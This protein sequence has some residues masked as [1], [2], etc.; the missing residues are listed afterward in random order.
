M[1]KEKIKKSRFFRFTRQ[2]WVFLLFAI[3]IGAAAVIKGI[4]LIYLVF[5]MMICFMF[6]SSILAIIS[7]HNLSIAR[8]VPMHIFAGKPFPVEIVI[9]NKK[10][11]Y[12]SFSLVI[13]DILE[14]EDLKNRYLI[15]VPAQTSISTT[16]Q[17]CIQKRGEYTFQGLKISTNY[18]LDFFSRGFIVLNPEKIVVYP[19]IVRLNP[20][21]LADM[22]IE[23][24]K[25]LDREGMGSEVYGFRKYQHGDDSRFI[26]WKLSAKTSQLIVTKFSQDQN[27]N[28]CI[29]FDNTMNEITDESLE[30]FESTVTFTASV[31]SFFV[32]KGFKVKLVTHSGEIPFGE[33]NK[34]LLKMLTHLALIQPISADKATKDIYSRN[35]LESAL[36]ILISYEKSTRSTSNF[37]HTFYTHGI[38]KF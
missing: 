38:E 19:K 17:H 23:I 5:S 3:V 11:F 33:G 28:V 2:G 29:V 26:N 31:S 7:L 18:P 9:T 13:N 4:N 27:L 25:V 34:Q 20:N 1:K 32:E 35:V 14:R 12:P 8:V 37:I 10:R 24:E 16:Y 30:Q 36:G 21:F 15:K 22:I 6:F